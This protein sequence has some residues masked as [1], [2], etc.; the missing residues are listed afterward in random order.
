[1][2]VL[3]HARSGARVCPARLTQEGLEDMLP[4]SASLAG[5]AP[6]GAWC[7]ACGDWSGGAAERAGV[8][9]PAP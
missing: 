2:A 9:D 7:E 8:N 4:P 6:A 5:V 1:M 3:L